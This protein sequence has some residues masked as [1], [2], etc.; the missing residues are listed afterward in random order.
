MVTIA[1]ES[2]S[3]ALEG[4]LIRVGTTVPPMVSRS[5]ISPE[6]ELGLN[7]KEMPSNSKISSA[8]VDMLHINKQNPDRM[9]L[10]IQVPYISFILEDNL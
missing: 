8:L 6:L 10:I 7:D 2:D 5:K 3:L 1:I 4:W 9:S